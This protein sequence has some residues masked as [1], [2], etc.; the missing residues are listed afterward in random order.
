M[1]NKN[2]SN[3]LQIEGQHLFEDLDVVLVYEMIV[4]LE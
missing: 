3:I 4:Y 1:A 2:V